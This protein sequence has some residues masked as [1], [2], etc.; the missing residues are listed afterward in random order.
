MTLAARRQEG[1]VVVWV[2]LLS[3]SCTGGSSRL[4]QV[5]GCSFQAVSHQGWAATVGC[6]GRRVQA[7]SD[8][9]NM[10]AWSL[11]CAPHFVMHS[12]SL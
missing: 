11:A 2:L 10:F 1:A 3:I 9:A 6:D 4:R 5:N 8:G 12:E 7:P